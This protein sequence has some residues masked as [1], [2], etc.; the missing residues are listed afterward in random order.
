MKLA[1]EEEVG[2]DPARISDLNRA[3]KEVVIP[4]AR[5]VYS[6]Y[7]TYGE[8]VPYIKN[9]DFWGDL[10]YIGVH[11]YEGLTNEKDPTVA[12]LNKGIERVFSE[13]IEPAQ[14]KYDRPVFFG[15]LAYQSYDG[16]NMPRKSGYRRQWSDRSS[17]EID[18]QE[19]ADEFEATFDFM[20]EKDYMY[21]AVLF[22]AGYGVLGFTQEE[23]RNGT[24]LG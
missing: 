13:Y 4:N 23:H 14:E 15:E 3:F 20:N 19:Q 10:D 8:N 11:F 21:G 24:Y 18:Y 16:D 22:N 12:E 2:D 5:S 6:G 9:I 17:Y 1:G 7:L